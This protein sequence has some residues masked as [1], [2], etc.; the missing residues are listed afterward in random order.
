MNTRNFNAKNEKPQF[1]IF[2]C[3]SPYRVSYF[4]FTQNASLL[5]A[6]CVDVLPH[7]KQFSVIL[8]GF[9]TIQLNSDTIYPETTSDSTG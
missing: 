6:K 2:S 5:V 1:S 3:R 9:P 8:Y 4:L 7:A